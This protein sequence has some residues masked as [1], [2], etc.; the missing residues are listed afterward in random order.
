MI[1]RFPVLINHATMGHK[2]HGQTKSSLCISDWHYG[3]T[4]PYVVLSRVTS[5]RGLF[6]LKPLLADHDFSHDERLTQMLTR[7]RMKAPLLYNDTD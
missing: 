7:M 3:A 1:N 4:W 5:L 2:L 6:L